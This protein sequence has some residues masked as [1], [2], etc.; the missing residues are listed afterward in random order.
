MRITSQSRRKG[1]S[2]EAINSHEAIHLRRPTAQ[3]RLAVI[4]RERRPRP[5]IKSRSALCSAR[6]LRAPSAVAPIV[7]RLGKWPDRNQNAQL[8]VSYAERDRSMHFQFNFRSFLSLRGGKQN[9][10][11][12]ASE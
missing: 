4:Q 8:R 3:F 5:N 7:Y 10:Q 6:P 9:R 12:A 1:D 11:C 2:L